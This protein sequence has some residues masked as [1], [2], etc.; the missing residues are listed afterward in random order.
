MPYTQS[1]CTSAHPIAILANIV[2]ID[3]HSRVSGNMTM[4]VKATLKRVIL[5]LLP[6]FYSG[7]S[8]TVPLCGTGTLRYG[9]PPHHLHVPSL[10]AHCS[11][12][13]T[14]GYN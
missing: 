12:P 6:A 8:G 11:S 7:D 3:V 4:A 10:V 2:F 13:Y 9:V 5:P 14:D 1:Q